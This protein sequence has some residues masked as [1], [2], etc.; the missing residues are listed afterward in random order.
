MIPMPAYSILEQLPRDQLPNHQPYEL[1][2][3]AA[4]SNEPKTHLQATIGP[5]APK[6]AHV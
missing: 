6:W 1:A 5:D 2:L 4:D 3:M